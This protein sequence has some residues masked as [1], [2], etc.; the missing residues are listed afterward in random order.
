MAPANSESN[1]NEETVTIKITGHGI[2]LERRLPLSWLPRLT[3]LLFGSGESVV[4]AATSIHTSDPTRV[5]QAVPGGF[6]ERPV[7]IVEYIR[8]KRPQTASD[9]ILVLAGHLELSENRRPFSRDDLRRLMRAARIPEP[10]NFPRDVGVAVAKGYIQP[11]GDG[12][13]LTN[14]GLEL[15]GHPGPL[16]A[17]RGRVGLRGRRKKEG[18]ESPD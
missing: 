16:I 4:A 5:S 12:F 13:Q 7:G 9:T 11:L 3:Q 14:T 18:G 1:E 6:L 17:P 8:E 10:A 15:V 2:D